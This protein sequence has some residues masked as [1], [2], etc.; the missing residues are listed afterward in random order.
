MG[1][2]DELESSSSRNPL[3]HLGSKADDGPSIADRH[4]GEAE[5]MEGDA[6][7]A[8]AEAA[9]SNANLRKALELSQDAS[10]KALNAAQVVLWTEAVAAIG[11]LAG[12][13]VSWVG[14]KMDDAQLPPDLSIPQEK[15]SLPPELMR[16]PPTQP[17]VPEPATMTPSSGE[18]A[19]GPSASRTTRARLGD[20]A[21]ETAESSGV[22]RVVPGEGEDVGTQWWAPGSPARP[23]GG[24]PPIP[25]QAP[26]WATQL[27]TSPE[28]S[29]RGLFAAGRPGGASAAAAAAAAA[30][31]EDHDDRPPTRGTTGRIPTWAPVS[32]VGPKAKGQD[33]PKPAAASAPAAIPKHTAVSPPFSPVV[34]AGADG[35]GGGAARPALSVPSG[36]DA[37]SG[38]A[39]PQIA[40]D[41]NAARLPSA[42]D[43]VRRTS[44]GQLRPPGGLRFGS[45]VEQNE[46]AP[47]VTSSGGGDS[48]PRAPIAAF[49]SLGAPSETGGGAEAAGGGAAAAGMA[50]P[51]NVLGS[52]P[53]E[54]Y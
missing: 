30:A 10:E 34:M 41:E 9:H 45:S 32:G 17:P 31:E 26:A 8:Q 50:T 46:P 36:A 25:A 47:S 23:T 15:A 1:D 35:A 5:K 20:P 51:R 14:W 42:G 21:D 53:S 24:A 22:P 11:T 4:F 13:L 7:D 43:S 2:D 19:R 16:P 52:E 18:E 6:D 40:S 3:H 12:C 54:S 37:G 39:L 27:D 28:P 38:G 29:P 49:Q 44:S 33:L 48:L